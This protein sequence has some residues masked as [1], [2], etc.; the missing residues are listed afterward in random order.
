MSHA[1]GLSGT[2]DSPLLERRDESILGELLGEAD[3]AHDARESGDEPRR[4][5]PPD[6]FDRAMCVG[7]RHGYR[8][9]HLQ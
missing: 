1:P 6:C 3:V 8:S 9:H 2:P 5:D 4:L 7:S